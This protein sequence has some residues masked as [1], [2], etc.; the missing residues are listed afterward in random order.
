LEIINGF[1]WF[2]PYARELVSSYPWSVFVP[3]LARPKL[4]L[5]RVDELSCGVTLRDTSGSSD[6]ALIVTAHQAPSLMSP[7]DLEHWRALFLPALSPIV[8]A[9]AHNGRIGRGDPRP[10]GI[11]EEDWQLV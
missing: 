4:D 8:N 2:E 11:V 7:Q 5:A 9:V 1:Q 10:P 6:G 3:G